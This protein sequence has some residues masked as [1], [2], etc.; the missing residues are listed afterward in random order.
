[1]YDTPGEWMIGM[2][3]TGE[4]SVTFQNDDNPIE[5]LEYNPE[6]F[7]D[8]I[9][10]F[11]SYYNNYSAAIDMN[12]NE[13][14]NTGGGN[15]FV[16]FTADED[17][18]FFGGKVLPELNSSL[19]G[20]EFS[21]EN[22]I[23]WSE[24]IDTVL[25]QNE[26]FIQH[27]IIRLPNGNY[28]GFVP[29]IETH[30][31]P[32]YTNYPERN[33]PFSWEDDCELYIEFNS[34]FDWKGEKIVEWNSAG[35]IVWEWDAFDYYNINDFDYLAGHWETAC[36]S[37]SAYDWIHFNAMVYNESEDALYV[38]SRHLDRITK[39]DYTSKNLIWNMGIQWLGDEVIVPDT[40][41]SGQHG[42][43]VLPNGNIVTLDN[44]ILSQY[45]TA[46]ITSPISRAIE[47][48][49]SDNNGSYSATTVWS[50]PLPYDL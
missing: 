42:L 3:S 9:T 47:I 48:A 38:S 4:S 45:T 21:L 19:I 16:F 31:V 28:M 18:N 22:E 2:F 6:L 39:I 34:N 24:P 12:G 33:T 44:G 7:S 37:S 26:S 23:L 1:M 30:P 5:I 43:Q 10:F 27:E 29:I 32:T 8:G 40:L 36:N 13:V 11:G 35:E 17:N 14:W 50:H 25:L 15:S 49:I 46:G 20:S 41:F